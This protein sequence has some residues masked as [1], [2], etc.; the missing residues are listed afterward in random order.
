MADEGRLRRSTRSN[1]GVPPRRYVGEVSV[2]AQETEDTLLEEI[3][4]LEND[5][6]EISAEI[7]ATHEASSPFLPRT[8]T[9]SKEP[10][11]RHAPEHARRI[12]ELHAR[13]RTSQQLQHEQ[14]HAL[15]RR[16]TLVHVNDVK[17]S[18]SH[19][20]YGELDDRSDRVHVSEPQNRALGAEYMT[21]T[22]ENHLNPDLERETETNSRRLKEETEEKEK[23][24][25]VQELQRLLKEQART[26]WAREKELQRQLHELG[27][28]SMQHEVR[29]EQTQQWSERKL[30]E[31]DRDPAVSGPK[32]EALNPEHAVVTQLADALSGAMISK[33]GDDMRR[34]MARQTTSSRELPVFSGEPE[35]WPVFFEQFRSTTDECQFSNAE[36][37]G[38]LR[39]CLKGKARETVS[40]ML[41]VPDNLQGVMDCLERRFGRPEVIVQT[42]IRKARSLPS[43]KDGDM[44]GLIDLSNAVNNLV[45]TMKLLRSDGHLSNPELRQNLVA[46]LPTT[47]QLHWGEHVSQRKSMGDVNL[48]DF[49]TWLTARADAASLVSDLNQPRS[50]N[51]K[52]ANSGVKTHFTA[53]QT[54]TGKKPSANKT[55]YRC[56][57][58]NEEGHIASSCLKFLSFHWRETRMGS[59]R[60]KM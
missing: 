49:S 53:T 8:S 6:L 3:Q 40:A 16:N 23:N 21:Y 34:F 55:K 22:P 51:P 60:E 54:S 58:C 47:I 59:E 43:P 20:H 36:N 13:A 50:V 17:P 41:A 15:A 44:T 35:D 25:D 26:F 46:K 39:K 27:Q 10:K 30:S 33:T 18:P 24:E 48:A 5:I 52:S 37:M 38:R 11:P 12:Q 19:V 7:A 28:R 42:M 1:F 2:Y 57:H 14:G 56:H 32:V 9:C 29:S 31:Q 4:K 45:S